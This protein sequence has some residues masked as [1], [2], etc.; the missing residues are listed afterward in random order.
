MTLLAELQQQQLQLSKQ[1]AFYDASAF[2]EMTSEVNE[3][4]SNERKMRTKKFHTD[5]V[6]AISGKCFWLAEV[7]F[8]RSATQ[9]NTSSVWVFALIL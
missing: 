8:P 4:N 7:N 5:Y 9:Y 3:Q 2:L 1:Q 6:L